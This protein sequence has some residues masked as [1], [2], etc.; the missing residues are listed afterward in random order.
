MTSF[1]PVAYTRPHLTVYAF[2][3]ARAFLFSTVY[4]AFY[5][6]IYTLF[7]STE[8][9][10]LRARGFLCPLSASIFSVQTPDSMAPSDVRMFE[11]GSLDDVLRGEVHVVLQ[12]L[13]Q[14][15]HPRGYSIWRQGFGSWVGCQ[16]RAPLS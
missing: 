10:S 15:S 2:L 9:M 6:M 11:K 1:L 3:K 4:V 13:C 5:H 16:E 12:S 8:V 14:D 7:S